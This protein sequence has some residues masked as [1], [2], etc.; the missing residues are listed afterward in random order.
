MSYKFWIL[1]QL[2]VLLFISH[3]SVDVYSQ[4]MWG[5]TTSNYAGSNSA[6]LN[7]SGI[8]TSKIYLDVNLVT[9]DLFFD[10]NYAYI[11]AK[12]YSL[13][14]YLKRDPEWPKYGPDELPVDRYSSQI[15]K[16]GHV[17]LLLK[18]PSAMLSW[19]RHAFAL[20]T[21]IRYMTSLTNVPYHI[22][23]FAY[24]GLDYEEQH[25]INYQ[26]KNINMGS[27][28]FGEV[29]VTYAFAFRKI[30]MEDWSAGITI[31]RLFGLAGAYLDAR[32]L[33]Y[34]T[35][36]DSTI[37]IKNI[38]S[39]LGFSVPL[40]YSSND[41]PDS[42]PTIKGGGFGF[43]VGITYQ[44]KLAPYHKRPFTSFCD[45]KYLDYLYKIGF[46][47]LDIGYVRFTDNAQRHSYDDR[48]RYWLNADTITYTSMNQLMASLSQ[49]FYD[50]P[51]ASYRGDRI[52]VY[53]PAAF[54]IQG[55]YKVYRNWYLGGVF[56]HSIPIFDGAVTRPAQVMVVP[57]YETFSFEASLP[58]SLFEWTY[59]RVGLSLR[60]YYLTL[61]TDNLLALL[62]F[63]DFTGLDLYLSL[64][65]HFGKGL[66]RQGSKAY[67]CQNF[68]YPSRE[69][70]K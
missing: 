25:N 58:V 49:V 55:D 29:G 47:L 3:F 57:R 11:H 26:N 38:N 63:T 39:E 22:A 36:N 69:K 54:S 60:Y 7:P 67:K 2:L 48:S 27:L 14:R 21:G 8:V 24:Y 68:E 32:D 10:N 33:N 34:T 40:D 46:S 56:I 62:G 16:H 28:A 44:K 51:Q 70:R 65:V 18:G 19:G 64:K 6:L 45:Q 23:N 17:N 9:S 5:I 41:F 53:L 61:G 4:E 13:F 1:K 35:I 50:D 59:P 37:D 20:H 12:D 31:R 66:C 30:H 15:P 52:T 43:D 42:G